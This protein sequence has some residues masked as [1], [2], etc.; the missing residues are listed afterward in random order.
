MDWAFVGK[1]PCF[2]LVELELLVRA[3]ALPLPFVPF[4]LGYDML[5]SFYSVELPWF[6]F[7]LFVLCEDGNYTILS[8]AFLL[9]DT[10]LTLGLHPRH[11]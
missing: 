1:S 6:A 8:I 3:D 2:R 10:I 4:E 5:V 9:P 7:L 11:H